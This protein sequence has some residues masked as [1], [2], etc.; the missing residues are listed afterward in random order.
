MIFL[1]TQGIQLQ[2]WHARFGDLLSIEKIWSWIA[3]KL[4]FYHSSANTADD[5]LHKLEAA[6][7]ELHISVIQD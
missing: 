7:N 3:E 1:D 4:A 2:S 5:A 6:W